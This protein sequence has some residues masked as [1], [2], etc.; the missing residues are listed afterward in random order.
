MAKASDRDT[1]IALVELGRDD[2]VLN[3]ELE[4]DDPEGVLV[5]GFKDDGAGGS[6]LLDL[7]PAAGTDAPVIAGFKAGKTKLRHRGAEIVAESLGGLEERSIDDAAD[8]VDAVVVGAGLAAAGAVEAGHRLATADI[9]RLA[10]D[11]LAAV[12]DGF[13]A[14]HKTLFSIEYPTFEAPLRR[15]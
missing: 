9:K 13:D 10:E 11:I 2:R 14:R 4:R 15:A 7:Q 5:G 12:L 6:G 3:Q 8:C 1:G